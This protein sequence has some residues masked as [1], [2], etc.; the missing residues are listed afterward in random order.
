MRR[1]CF[2]VPAS[3]LPAASSGLRRWTFY[4]AQTPK[5]RPGRAGDVR[6]TSSKTRLHK[7]LAEGLKSALERG[8]LRRP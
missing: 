1:H 7:R 5:Q 6:P 3:V 2:F 8:T 4:R